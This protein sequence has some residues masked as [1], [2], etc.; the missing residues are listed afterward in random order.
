MQYTPVVS[1]LRKLKQ[2][3]CYKYQK[4]QGGLNYRAIHYPPL[5]YLSPKKKK[6]VSHHLPQLQL[7]KY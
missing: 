7:E 1:A 2:E 5:P 6:K 4:F 3:D